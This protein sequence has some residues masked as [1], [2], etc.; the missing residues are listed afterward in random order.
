[1]LA[2]YVSLFMWWWLSGLDLKSDVAV[3][4][5]SVDTGMALEYQSGLAE[6]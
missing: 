2:V 6:S 5:L 4:Q 1:M 3:Q